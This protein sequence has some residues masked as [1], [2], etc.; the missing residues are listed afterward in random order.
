MEALCDLLF[1][2]S[3][4][5]RMNIIQSLIKERLRLSQVSKNLDMTLTEAS[6][7]MQ[8][9]SDVHLISKDVDGNFGLTPYGELAFSLLSS[10]SFISENNEYFLKHDISRIPSEFS[11]RINELSIGKLDSNVVGVL[12]YVNT[13]IQNAE[14]YF[15]VMSYPQTLPNT[16]SLVEEKM[17][18]GASIRR[19]HPEA[20]NP[21]PN[22]PILKDPRRTLPQIDIRIIMNEKEAMC[23]FPLLDGKI[24]YTSFISKDPKFHKWCRDIFLY[25]WGKAKPA[26]S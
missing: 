9:L 26:I 17:K 25:Y 1:E 18:S 11:S 3:S 10:L 4:V 14:E 21:I 22:T 24:D 2:F 7:H 8:R 5:E 16:L 23:S 19:I 13:M 6:R 20:I 12:A 15:W